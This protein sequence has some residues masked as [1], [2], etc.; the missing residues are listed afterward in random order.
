MRRQGWRQ[1]RIWVPD[2]RAEAARASLAEQSRAIAANSEDERDVM[3][4]IG[5]LGAW[6][7]WR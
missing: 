2:T 3:G 6:S 4:W 5:G 1:V 7:D